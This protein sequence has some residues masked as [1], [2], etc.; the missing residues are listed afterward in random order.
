MAVF[1]R[2]SLSPLAISAVYYC[3]ASRKFSRTPETMP[4]RE[5][6]TS[7]SHPVNTRQN[8]KP[9]F[10]PVLG[11]V[12]PITEAQQEPSR[13]LTPAELAEQAH[14]TKLTQQV[15]DKSF[16]ETQTYTQAQRLAL[17]AERNQNAI[18][19]T[20]AVRVAN[21]IDRLRMDLKTWEENYGKHDESGCAH[22]P[23]RLLRG[24][25]KLRATIRV[26]DALGDK[27]TR[28][29]SSRAATPKGATS[30]A[31]EWA[32]YIR[33]SLLKQFYNSVGDVMEL[34]RDTFKGSDEAGG[35]PG[36]MLEALQ[37]VQG[38][39][40]YCTKQNNRQGEL[41]AGREMRRLV[42]SEFDYMTHE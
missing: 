3:T 15:F 31:P 13:I 42:E 10:H 19:Q 34:C 35:V 17:E 8:T 39:A 7:I 37:G 29:P 22:L 38:L 14:M 28:S 27:S 33:V 1:L 24:L 40:I 32:H 21:Y 6:T 9:N 4:G 12:Y 2:I 20:S 18:I 16:R 41:A 11:P 25:L 26:E 5:H 36:F 30:A 23:C